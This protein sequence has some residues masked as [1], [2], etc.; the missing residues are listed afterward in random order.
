[1]NTTRYAQLMTVAMVISRLVPYYIIQDAFEFS[2]SNLDIGFFTSLFKN[3]DLFLLLYCLPPIMGILTIFKSA[4]L[5]PTAI[6][7]IFS[8]LFLLWHQYSYNDATH[9]VTFWSGIFTLWLLYHPAEKSN[10]SII[11][12]LL[13]IMT[14][15]GGVTGK[16]TPG[17]LNGEILYEIYFISRDFWSY[18]LLRSLFHHQQLPEVALVYSRIILAIECTGILLAFINHRIVFPLIATLFLAIAVLNNWFLFSVV[19]CPIAIAT[20]GFLI[21]KTPKQIYHS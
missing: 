12:R 11:A 8:S 21:S 5:K 2:N 7:W 4:L 19:T 10:T 13:L 1:M 18:N 9:V 6:A 17:Y 20:I 14:L 3:N 16:L 15:C